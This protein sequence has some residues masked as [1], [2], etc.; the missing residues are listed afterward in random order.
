M[1]GL[2]ADR[3]DSRPDKAWDAEEKEDQD[4][5]KKRPAATCS[6]GEVQMLHDSSPSQKSPHGCRILAF[7]PFMPWANL[8]TVRHI[9]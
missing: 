9:S 7:R 6:I 8:K 3:T 4:D 5:R 2:F 1:I